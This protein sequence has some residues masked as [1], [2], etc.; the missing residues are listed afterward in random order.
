MQIVID[1]VCMSTHLIKPDFAAL[2][3]PLIGKKLLL[4]CSQHDSVDCFLNSLMVIRIDAL[5]KHPKGIDDDMTVWT[6]NTHH[7]CQGIKIPYIFTGQL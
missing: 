2:I 3:F 7:L 6:G 1:P 5:H 4:A